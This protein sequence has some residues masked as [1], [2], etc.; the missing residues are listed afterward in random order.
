MGS[1]LFPAVDPFLVGEFSS[2]RRVGLAVGR[3]AR[4]AQVLP[5]LP[6]WGR[7]Q[8]AGWQLLCDAGCQAALSL[9]P[10]SPC[11]IPRSFFPASGLPLAAA[12]RPWQPCWWCRD[13]QTILSVEM[14]QTRGWLVLGF[15][16]C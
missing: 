9:L 10:P 16:L 6:H 11:S 1:Q 15:V 13:V 12:M 3:L 2:G 8:A 7:D 14:S 5:L 4:G